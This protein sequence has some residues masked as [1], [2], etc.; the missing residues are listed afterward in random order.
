MAAR[1]SSCM[2]QSRSIRQ[3]RVHEMTTGASYDETKRALNLGAKLSIQNDRRIAHFEE[4]RSAMTTQ[5]QHPEVTHSMNYQSDD[6][7]R[8]THSPTLIRPRASID[9]AR[10]AEKAIDDH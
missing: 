2:T 1:R 4:K 7:H 3:A 5:G 9:E 8:K 6:T 10:E